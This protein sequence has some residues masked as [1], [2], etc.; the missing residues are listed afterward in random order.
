MKNALSF[1]SFLKNS[2]F[3]ITVLF[4]IFNFQ[5]AT[6]QNPLEK[7]RLEI[8]AR[9]KGDYESLEKDFTALNKKALQQNNE[10]IYFKTLIHLCSIKNKTRKFN[11]AIKLGNFTVDEAQKRN[12]KIAEMLAYGQLS[13]AYSSLELHSRSKECIDKSLEIEKTIKEVNDSMQHIK[14]DAF[15]YASEYYGFKGDFKNSLA[16]YKKS[17]KEFQQIKDPK[18]RDKNLLANYSNLAKTYKYL[19]Q[20]DSMYYYSKKALEL[21]PVK[22]KKPSILSKIYYHFGIY[23]SSKGNYKL[24]ET[25]FLKCLDIINSETKDVAFKAATFEQMG[26]NYE[27]MND[28][29]NAI[30]YKDLV[31]KLNDSID[32][33]SRKELDK[34][35]NTVVDKK[36]TEVEETKTKSIVLISLSVLAAL[37][38]SFFLYKKLKKTKS[39]KEEISHLLEKEKEENSLLE[40]KVNDSFNE[41]IQLAQKNS[42]NFY[43]KFSEVYPEVNS[44]LS[45]DYP[46][47]S[48]FEKSFLAMVYLNFSNKELANIESVSS[49]TIEIR[50]YRIRKKCNLDAGKDLKEWLTELSNNKKP[51][52]HS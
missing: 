47:L 10:E 5:T 33:A 32:K 26:K 23:N 1:L 41:V 42:P 48:T 16:S 30:K 51:N 38:I 37:V 18:I 36:T 29:K 44:I 3:A 40:S 15:Y 28:T 2:T 4:I 17:L 24:A 19:D 9:F 35:L 43:V 46:Q 22:F 11:D 8:F 50:K 13:T 21:D 45:R 52:G 6:A 12:N 34:T 31:F 39:E 25:N 7:E 27:K 49:K 14:G 20:L